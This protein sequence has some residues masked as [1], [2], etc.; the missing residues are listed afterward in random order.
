MDRYLNRVDAPTLFYRIEGAGP[1]VM[2]I[3][4]VGA[5]GSSWDAIARVLVSRFAVLRLD[6]REHGRSGHIGSE[7]SLGDF[8]RD[9]V[10]VLDTTDTP[11]AHIVGFSLGGMIAQALALDHASR[12]DRLVL[13]SAVAGRTA[14]ERARVCDRLEILR[15]Q[16]IAAISSAAQDRWFTDGFIASH[17][18]LVRQRMEQLQR[19]HPASYAAAYTA[20]FSTSDLGE[21]LHAIDHPTLVATGEHDVGSNTR[22]ARFMQ[23]QIRGAKLHILPGLKH[24]ILAEAPETIATMLVEFLA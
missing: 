11:R 3:H 23:Q 5:D 21:R 8:T 12:V 22:M 19:N 17:P 16:G 15:T 18:Q 14:Q 7:L 20:V 9:V 1:P 4:G 10:D 13:L 6:L 2:L 24:S